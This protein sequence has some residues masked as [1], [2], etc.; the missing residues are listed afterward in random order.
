MKRQ[1]PAHQ[2]L[3]MLI[4]V[5]LP[6]LLIS[7]ALASGGFP[8]PGKLSAD[9]FSSIL[10]LM[11]YPSSQDPLQPSL[12]IVPSAL[13]LSLP[14][15]FIPAAAGIRNLPS[16][17]GAAAALWLR[18]ERKFSEVPLLFHVSAVWHWTDDYM[19]LVHLALVLGAGL[20][21]AWLPH[22]GFSDWFGAGAMLVLFGLEYYR[23]YTRRTVFLRQCREDEIKRGQKGAGFKM[24]V[25]Y[26]DSDCRSASIYN[27]VVRIMET[28]RPYLQEDFTI[29][30]LARMTRT[31]RLY[32]SKSI[33]FHSGRNFNQLIN[34]YRVKYAVALIKKDPSLKMS[35]VATMCGFHTVV[36]FNMAFKLNE[37]IT[38]SEFARSLKTLH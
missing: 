37:R 10:L 23:I 18:A 15:L 27:D 21:L 16:F 6:L 3:R 33:N 22:S 35:E 1:I 34:F 9:I 13:L 5:S 32:L 12:M 2:A 29:D 30:D 7:D 24:P 4:L 20:L 14:L 8:G 31:N 25:Q 28:S 38:P 11:A 26:V 36:S 19:Y 17:A